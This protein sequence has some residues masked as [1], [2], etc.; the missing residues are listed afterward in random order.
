M[1]V[2]LSVSVAFLSYPVL[3]PSA[4]R[5]FGQ[6]S[7]SR[8]YSLNPLPLWGR[9]PKFTFLIGFGPLRAQGPFFISGFCS[10]PCGIGHREGAPGRWSGKPLFLQPPAGG[11]AFPQEGLGAYLP[12]NAPKDGHA[13]PRRGWS[14]LGVASAQTGY[15]WFDPPGEG[16][17]HR[18][19][20]GAQPQASPVVLRRPGDGGK[21]KETERKQ[22]GKRKT[23]SRC[24]LEA[25]NW[26]DNRVC[27][28]YP[29]HPLPT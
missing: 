12:R 11:W 25:A 17:C 20:T 7:F 8:F 27:G 14:P 15:R 1:V 5:W 29:P 6:A 13:F 16:L 9:G 19:T 18:L 24:P 2:F 4:G 26:S 23:H 21:R 10:R 22:K 28:P 3:I